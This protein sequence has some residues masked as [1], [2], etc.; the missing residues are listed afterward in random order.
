MSNMTGI[1]SNSERKSEFDAISIMFDIFVHYVKNGIV[2]AQGPVNYMQPYQ[3]C[4]LSPSLNVYVFSFRPSS[5]PTYQET[6]GH[7]LSGSKDHICQLWL[8]D[9]NAF[10]WFLFFKDGYHQN[11]DWRQQ[12][13]Q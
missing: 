9:F 12:K 10:Y 1:V 4:N 6:T 5:K 11:Y 13:K 2:V 7:F 3:L 8:V